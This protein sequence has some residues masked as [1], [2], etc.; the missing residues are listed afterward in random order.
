MADFDN[1]PL[2]DP[3]FIERASAGQTLAEALSFGSPLVEQLAVSAREGNS[4]TDEGLGADLMGM[5]YG[6]LAT[7]YGE[8]VAGNRIEIQRELAAQRRVQD[9]TRTNGQIVADT[10]LGAGAG[11]VGLVGGVSSATLG[12]AGAVDQYFDP[13]NTGLSELGVGV[14]DITSTATGFITGLQSNEL[15]ARQNLSGVEAQL[16][17][18]DTLAQYEAEVAAG[19]NS[20]VAGLTQVGRDAL[21]TGER[22]L[23]D[24]AVL[25]D[26][27]AQALGS[28]GPSAKLASGG[29]A[30][31]RGATDRFTR[32]EFAIKLANATGTIP[33][34]TNG[35][36]IASAIGVS[37]GVGVAEASGAYMDTA[38]SVMARTHEQMMTSPEYTAMIAQG[39]DPIQAQEL[40]ASSTALEAFG[41]QF[42]TA[43]ALTLATGANAF[44]AAP[45]STIRGKGLVD[46]FR[47]MGSQALEEGF[48][49]AS[50]QLNQNIAIQNQ[51]DASQLLSDGLGEQ[52]ATGAIAGAG[53]AGALAGPANAGSIISDT[54]TAGGTAISAIKDNLPNL[55]TLPTLGGG[56]ATDAPVEEATQ[57]IPTVA[58]NGLGAVITQPTVST[59]VLGNIQSKNPT[60]LARSDR[61][62]RAITESSGYDTLSAMLD[63]HQVEKIAGGQEKVVLR[64]DG[65]IVRISMAEEAPTYGNYDKQIKPLFA[66]V[67]DD[68][69]IEIVEEV[70]MD[71]SKEEIIAFDAQVTTDG[72]FWND[73]NIDNVG[74]S[75]DGSLKIIDGEV[76]PSDRFIKDGYG[77]QDYR[78]TTQEGDVF[79]P[80]EL[81]LN[82]I[83]GKEIT[84]EEIAAVKSRPTT[85]FVKPEAPVAPSP[86]KQALNSIANA[87]TSTL[88]SVKEYANSTNVEVA[89]K[90]AASAKAAEIIGSEIAGTVD[91]AKGAV[92]D[93]VS[94][95]SNSTIPAAFATSVAAGGNVLSNVSGVMQNLASPETKMKDL[96]DSAVLFA[97]ENFQTLK[98]A[99]NGLPAAIKTEVA[100]VIS[101]E[102]FKSV[103][104]AAKKIDLNTTQTEE[105]E[106]TPETVTDT[107][108]V[109]KTNPTNVNPGFINKILEQPAGTVSPED[110]KL[111]K[112]AASIAS[113]VNNHA[114]EKVEIIKADGVALSQKPAYQA[115]PKALE[116][117]QSAAIDKV[118][119]SV[120]VAG[121]KG[122]RSVNDFAADIFA[123]AQ[124]EAG[125]VISD[126]VSIP[127]GKVVE[128]FTNFRA[129]MENK[130]AALLES[131]RIFEET[132]KTTP[133]GF[134]SLSTSGKMVE[135][136][137]QGGA[138]PV[139]YQTSE[140]AAVFNASLANDARVTA[141][142]HDVLAQTFPELFA[143]PTPEVQIE[144]VSNEEVAP[145]EATV[146]EVSE[147]EAGTETVSE[148]VQEEVASTVEDTTAVELKEEVLD[149]PA[150]ETTEET[151]TVEEDQAA[152]DVVADVRTFE[153]SEL[154][155]DTFTDVDGAAEYTDG[156]S[157]I[158]L[159]EHT[160][161]AKIAKALLRPM[162]VRM[163]QRLQ[164]V[165]F[166]KNMTVAE[167]LQSGAN[168]TA[169]RDYK[170]TLF[171]NLETMKYDP[172]L[173]SL[174]AVAVIDWMSSA[175]S[176]DPAQ[177]KET[178]EKLG[179]DY[180]NLSTEDMQNIMYGISTRQAAEAITR[181]VL[182]AW[183]LQ[184]N[185]DSSII[186]GRGSVESLVKELLTVSG[187]MGVIDINDIPT[188]KDGKEVMVQ[189]LNVKRLQKMQAK[190]GLGAQNA[191]Q[192][193]T[194]P[195]DAYGP[196]LNEK[197]A[198]VD[199][200]QSRGKVALSKI[201]KAALKA[202][203]DT[204]HYI[205]E[206]V[207]GL[208]SALGFEALNNMLGYRDDSA[209]GEKHPLRASIV[210]KNLSIERDYAD[211]MAV[212]DGI[213][214][215]S[216]DEAVAVYYPVGISK[217]GRHQFKGINPQNNKILR[218]MVTPTHSTLDMNDQQDVD[219]FWLTVAQAADLFKVENQNHKMI[220]DNVEADFNTRFGAATD[221]AQ[222]WVATGEMNSVAFA[223]AM[224][225]A[226][227]AEL[228]AVVAVAQLR[229]AEANGTQGEFQT[230]LS[231][232]LDGKTD[233]PANMMSNFG[234]GEVS[235]ADYLN[236]KRVGFFIGKVGETL[237]NFFTG[238]EGKKSGDLYEGT[239][240][241]ALQNMMRR[242]VKGKPAE[243]AALTAVANFS[244]A[245][246]DLKNTTNAKGENT[247]WEMTRTT[248]K[249]PMTKTVYGSGVRGVA[250][251]IAGD[252]VM[253]FYEKMLTVPAGAKASEFLG[254]PTLEADFKLLFGETFNDNINW[255]ES[256]LDKDST[257][258]FDELVEKGL[259]EIL[260]QTAKDVIGAPIT[261]VNDAL[262][263]LTGVQT[264]FLQ[265]LFE[266]RLGE[267]A[268]AEAVAGRIGRS[269][270]NN[271]PI[272]AQI[273]QRKYN[274][275]VA[276][277]RAYAPTY[278]NGT[279]TL[280]V[281]SFDN[282]V[283]NIELSSS[284]D[285]DMRMKSTM[286]SP[287]LAGVKVIPYLSIGR[288]DAMMMNT[289][290]SA[291]NAPTDT[292]PVFDGI[293]MPV[294][295]VREYAN[296]INEAVMQNWDRDVL[297][298]VETDF[299]TF[300]SSVGSETALLEAA[301][302][303]VKEAAEKNKSTVVA[304]T[305]DELL[306]AVKEFHRQNQ[307]R[308]AA[309]KRIP[310]S[311]DHMGGSNSSYSR[312]EGE[313]TLDEINALIR[314]ELNGVSTPVEAVEVDETD[315]GMEG[316]VEADAVEGEFS[317]LVAI[318]ASSMVQALLKETRN[319]L[320]NQTLKAIAPLIPAGA[321]VVT[322]NLAQLQAYREAHFAADGVTLTDAKG[323]YDVANNTIFIADNNHETIA[324]ELVHMV[325]FSKVLA[326]YEG[327]QDDAVVRLEGLMQ[328]FLDLNIKGSEAAQA[329]IL[330]NQNSDTAMSKAAALNE[331]MAWS[332]SNE[333]LIKGTQSAAATIVKK[334]KLLMQRLLGKVPANLFENILFNTV[335]LGTEDTGG[336]DD[337]INNNDDGGLTNDAHKFTN[338]WLDLVRDR[339][340]DSA[341]ADGTFKRDRLIEYADKA[342][343]ITVQLDFGG[344]NLSEYQK[345]TFM[346]IHTVLA[347]ELQLDPRSSV[348]LNKVFDHVIANLS[349]EMFGPVNQDERFSTVMDLF[350]KTKN[351]EGVSD[352]V[353]VLLA[354][355][356]TSNGFRAALDQLPEPESTAVNDGTL[357]S[358]LEN[359]SGTLMRK[360]IGTIDTAEGA[361][362][363]LDGLSQ[364]LIRQE[365]DKEF[366]VIRTLMS[367]VDKA[368]NWTKGALGKL[369]ERAD[370]VDRKMKASDRS[371]LTKL[372]VGSVAYAT[373]FVDE[374]RSKIALQGLKNA[375]HMG[376]ALDKFVPIREFIS[377][378]VGTDKI[379]KGVVALLD[380]TNFA[381]Q[382]VRQAY[383]E[384]LPGILARGFTKAPTP[385]Q[386]KSMHRILGKT[387]F[388]SI[389]SLANPQEAIRLLISDSRLNQKIIAAEKA[390]QK[391]FTPDAANAILEK[392]QQLANFMNG[393]GAG[394]QLWKNAY[395]INKLSGDYQSGLT[396]E[397]DQL[398]TM[399]AIQG[400]D[401]AA[402]REIVDIYNNDPE[403]IQNLVVYMQGLNKE[404]DSKVI[405]E[406]ARLNGYKGYIPDQGTGGS[407][408][409]IE[410]DAQEATMIAR[411]FTKLGKFTGQ[412]GFSNGSLSYYTTT[413]K[414]GGLY[415]QG[416]MQSVQSSYRGV[417]ATTGLT[418]NG[419]TS[420]VIRGEA[421]GVVTDELNLEGRVENDKEVLI[422]V[423]S[424]D[425]IIMYER[426]M[427]PDLLEA[428]TSPKSNLALMLGAWAGRQVE[429]Q[430]AKKYNA[431]L[432]GQLKTIWDKREVGSD[433]LFIDISSKDVDDKVFQ[434]IWR[435]IS[436]ETK[437]LI[438]ETF[439]EE[440]GFMIRKDMINLALGYREASITDVWSGK[441]RM[442]EV[443]TDTVKAVS[444][445]LLGDKAMTWASKGEEG[446]QGVVSAAKDIIVVRSL[447]VPALN[448]QANMFQLWT[449]GVGTKAAIRG[450]RDKLAEIEQ[451]NENVKS[452]IEIEARIQL[453]GM[454]KNKVSVLQQQRQAIWDQN[455][456]MT[457]AP[458]IAEGQYKNI[459]E[460]ITDMDVEITSGRLGDWVEAQV[461]K[462]PKGAQTVAKYGMLSKDTAIY[463][464]ANKAVQYGDFIAKGIYYDHLVGEGKTHAEAMEKVNEEFVNFSVLPGRSRSYLESMG[465]TWFMTF[466]IRIMKVALSML[467][468]NPVR[469]LITAGV[470]PDV[471]SPIGD[472]LIAKTAEGTIDYAIGT[473]MLF[474]APD[475]NPWVNLLD[476]AGE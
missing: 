420:G 238:E 262:V 162:M 160:E 92:A 44:N 26:V 56:N 467:Q 236:F 43:M 430:F 142:V 441:T 438:E 156:Q 222:E 193:I 200:T 298:D 368:D 217:V 344:F 157:L 299:E 284:M 380:K 15:Q 398:V 446:Y 174:A 38:N 464:G 328:E 14:A 356:Q 232:E 231:F 123:G 258:K 49:G 358:F 83:F 423:Q 175:R 296:Q 41:R 132:G 333:T 7:K 397:I 417:D 271:K 149:A 24:G 227:M 293:D 181:Q 377:E 192:K 167:A 94:K 426:A 148:T 315:I 104:A 475:L 367:S 292:L 425:G 269:K 89:V 116:K 267:L 196:S 234:Q 205:S 265:A 136:G 8:E 75:A 99:S 290:Y 165:K 186:D 431:E 349:P 237:N 211:A 130:A 304:K 118:S 223:D 325:S 219:A 119:R 436:P 383:R 340:A 322:G 5:T 32:N 4:L 19:G 264:E 220:L 460:G 260:S 17:A 274:A 138:K 300:L 385:A 444:K 311:V 189:T 337:N 74:R 413:V 318:D 257:K 391:N 182:K 410:D 226:S 346:A 451:Y 52:L 50:A 343:D 329:S 427:N 351:Q 161:Y 288:G 434:D 25:G 357:N 151:T 91:V 353:A 313:M 214:N 170:N 59:V 242:I 409:V 147:D 459:S 364:S 251:G 331:F 355:S 178:L 404:E 336:N 301:F 84:A 411:G 416:V 6:Q 1:S 387:D 352:A 366:S 78:A 295:K 20:F 37:A 388:A 372:I 396:A 272:V 445:R 447:V 137:G 432:V 279:Q 171:V 326:H 287:S 442:P 382:S 10:S 31:V 128:Q 418:V 96:G 323:M 195:E 48:Q 27:V 450:T 338:Y 207:S 176:T 76:F 310:L 173:L 135:V 390:V 18:A 317:K 63:G 180:S 213:H 268:E 218:A 202:M 327:S 275:L 45:L 281:G 197:L 266:K 469:S 150:A 379:N 307:A 408:L 67:I 229:H 204:P 247:G 454:D 414:Q 40:V 125:T 350:G 392:T 361:G 283:S 87:T 13:E 68:L 64:V 406:E 228:A 179:V 225:N 389:F 422:P 278:S 121:F 369:A 462:L 476:W 316:P 191:V 177:L 230:T 57:P 2:L 155:Q 347:M 113:A 455:S 61:T 359:I 144:E 198:Y 259:G 16:D 378:V 139:T 163:N 243:A 28:L 159:I 309:F 348:A 381:V 415:S 122:M 395:A 375:T 106:V 244:A 365:G 468:N 101:S 401:A 33:A 146:E 184:A 72:M 239:S 280:A 452:I 314:D 70:K 294:N 470:L 371:D 248:A 215:L 465:A 453:A 141:E 394:H 97:A 172:T 335:I 302:A 3:N 124:S 376:V 373:Q 449:R 168:P 29:A 111:L 30:L 85:P 472:N 330:L 140:K 54:F 114:G 252:M 166:N 402:K 143:Q 270:N 47:E 339:L 22:I 120:Q 115:N 473:D 58:E 263:F 319:K 261:R 433:D 23:S 153:L 100:K 39:I 206:G 35:Q 71:L 241:N 62:A 9:T 188:I 291:D 407:R 363:I 458:M 107:V 249:S 419:T 183:K 235:E 86:L 254:Y 312:G 435:V 12:T 286:Q 321:K 370:E 403:G 461:N 210:G 98:A 103:L 21:N 82:D 421:V 126:N 405:S 362:A 253:E 129:H 209:L 342:R 190:I 306:S 324:H 212:V 448:V 154:F 90:A 199:Q 55:P 34:I 360:S 185:A 110:V 117:K 256:F 11:F 289:I 36:R 51:V 79:T 112:A 105:T 187:E 102:T 277:L 341:N 164:T 474:G 158:D 424:A 73:A 255:A 216:S 282:N 320:V 127:V 440:D 224:G 65:Q 77:N 273:S 386:W 203:Q 245:F 145:E 80:P 152:A 276:E 305:S 88:S 285:G 443:V 471:G 345:Q 240:I 412:E 439:A 233:G 221:I 297:A 393:N 134:R 428:Y 354:L 246:G 466:K 437:A 201:E 109:A 93:V 131:K 108:I 400:Q 133:V 250:T 303:S 169:I 384:D 46:T 208:V 95:V 332:L 66:G 42:P 69:Y 457:I 308:K 194:S 399:Y 81:S 53:M 334:V 60:Q 374:G 463:R 456:R 429:E